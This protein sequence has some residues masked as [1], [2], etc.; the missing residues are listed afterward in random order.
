[1]IDA[2]KNCREKCEIFTLTSFNAWT[3]TN[4]LRKAVD[5]IKAHWLVKCFTAQSP[6]FVERW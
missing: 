2:V 6:F 3:G 5:R 4:L 1:M